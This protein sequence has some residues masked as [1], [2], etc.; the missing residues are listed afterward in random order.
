MNDGNYHFILPGTFV[1][2]TKFAELIMSPDKE[3]SQNI[4]FKQ[5]AINKFLMRAVIEG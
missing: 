5:T 2:Q 1:P 3:R 4:E